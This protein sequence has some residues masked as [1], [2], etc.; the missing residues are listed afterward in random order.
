MNARS[1]VVPFLIGMLALGW[2]ASYVIYRAAE[3]GELV[4]PLE[5]RSF[6]AFT[7]ATLGTGGRYEN[8][9]RLGPLN[10][11]GWGQHVVLVDVGRGTAEALRRALIPVSQPHTVYISNLMPENLMGLDDLLFTGWLE[12]RRQPVRVVGPVGIAAYVDAL[13]R[14]YRE[15]TRA[16]ALGLALPPLGAALTVLEVEGGWQEELD[17]MKVEAGEISG[18]PTPA[19]AWRFQLGGRSLVVSGTG[20]GNDDLIAFASGS[21]LLV[22]EAV[23]IPDPD[24]LEESGVIA[25]PERLRLEARLHTS[26]LDVGALATRANVGALA[27]VRMRP[28]PFFPLQARSLVDDTFS[29]RIIVPDDGDE[30]HP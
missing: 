26:I 24:Q 6:D 11:V 13:L 1:L 25:D 12:P 5:P 18:G 4:A 17:G 27:L 15:S 9:E 22:H 8:P 20:W 7:L 3:V 10:A 28:P 16:L 14:A 23:Y 2:F 30:L 19:L 21:H 29:G